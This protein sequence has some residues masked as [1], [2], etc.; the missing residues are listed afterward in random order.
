MPFDLDA[1]IAEG[2][3]P[4]KSSRFDLDA[5]IANPSEKQSAVKAVKDTALGAVQ[6]I[7]DVFNTGAQALQPVADVIDY[8][9][10]RL[11]GGT[12]SG[13]LHDSLG[14]SKTANDA[15]KAQQAGYEAETGNTTAAAGGRLIGNV[16]A[17]APLSGLR[18]ASESARVPMVLQ[19]VINGG[20]QGGAGAMAL[21]SSNQDAGVGTQTGLGAALGAALNVAVPPAVRVLAN[22]GRRGVDAITGRAQ[23]AAQGV[24][25]QA[26]RVIGDALERAGVGTD[27]LGAN[28]SVLRRDIERAIAAG[29]TIDSRALERRAAYHAVGAEPR[30]GTITRDPLQFAREQTLKGLEVGEP[31]ARTEAANNGRFI[32]LL[33]ERGAQQAPGEHQAGMAMVNRL[34]GHLDSG[35]AEISRL[36]QSARDANGRL[37]EIDPAAFATRAGDLLDQN[38]SN[39]FVPANVRNMMNDFATG[40]V[41][42]N[43]HTAEQ[44]KTIVG[45]AQRTTQDGNERFALG[46]VR[47][48]L[49]EAPL[50]VDSPA[51]QNVG[52]NLLASN[53]PAEIRP[54]LGQEAVDAF[55]QARAA[56]RNLRQTV[57]SSRAL[58]DIE[59]G[60]EPDRFFKRHILDADVAQV[61]RTVDLL[62]QDPQTLAA[63]KNQVV[64]YLKRQALN[65]ASDEIGRFSQAAY[66]KALNQMSNGGRL[67]ILFS[68]QEL[69]QLRLL[70][71][72]SS[73][74]Q[75]APIGAVVN[76]SGTSS[77]L[78]DLM[79][80][81]M[82]LPWV[83]EAVVEPVENWQRSGEVGRA[84]RASPV[85]RGR[86]S[87]QPVPSS[88][89]GAALLSGINRER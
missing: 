89:L 86:Q 7:N 1:A 72:V 4:K 19:R 35:E 29:D 39:A 43:V 75:A 76:N 16:A 37:A 71:R 88:P 2:G 84:V 83:R 25:D 69:R 81:S 60:M 80:R 62:R 63:V 45:R 21:S 53:L 5:A 85:V 74:E 28:A 68:P 38:L 55:N 8:G 66:N 46:L 42:L 6:G 61:Q 12:V 49:D 67:N 36:Y 9:V 82:R 18:V 33:N 34:Q 44:F 11:T 51:A 47:Q 40:K 13:L 73:Y 15:V 41:P 14:M 26:S 20:A 65:G 31:I 78:F 24:R 79:Q 59:N 52:E 58:Q 56:H 22:A 27:E 77:R 3:G 50:L 32:Q 23:Q 10:K 54:P 70:G 87:Q 48:A 17:T 30:L 57:E 64:D